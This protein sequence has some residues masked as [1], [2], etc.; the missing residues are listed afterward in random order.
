MSKEKKVDLNKLRSVGVN[1]SDKSPRTK[2]VDERGS[3]QTE[4]YSGRVDAQVVAPTV[5]ASVK[6][7]E[8]S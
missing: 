5:V 2:V 4:H 8:E 7:Q 1:T 3:T 6:V